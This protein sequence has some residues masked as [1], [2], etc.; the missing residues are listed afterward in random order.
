MTE[1]PTT[2]PT[3]LPAPEATRMHAEAS[4]APA[5]LERQMAANDGLIETLV[6]TLREREPRFVVTCARG[7]SDHAAT[8]AKYAI[9]TQLGIVTASASPSVES[10]YAVAQRLEGAVYL[11]ISQSGKS[12]DLVR[13]AEAARAAGAH[14]VALVNVEGSPLAEVADSVIPLRAGPETS[15]AATKSYLATLAAIVHLVARWTGHAPLINALHD[16]PE[17]MR[18]ALAQDWSPLVEGLHD[19]HNLFVLGRGY[20]YGAAQEMALKFKETSGLHAESFSSAEVRHGPMALVG[21]D[22]P[23]LAIGQADG[24]LD[25][26]LETVR[27]FRARGARVWT[28]IPGDEHA[29]A[30]PVTVAPHPLVAP[31]L[32]VQSF[33]PA[34]NALALSR[35]HNPDVPPYLNKV[36][37]TV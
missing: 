37:E 13:N 23:V 1:A 14:V 33:Y 11:V 8:F 29:D 22:F 36:T 3:P 34:V 16:T 25:G 21:E 28:S 6:A 19:A 10:V 2:T 26:T 15:V 18:R 12:P 30:L 9:E 7:S 20:G 32:A 4:E 31:L 5:V 35:G 17:A 27:D 24:T